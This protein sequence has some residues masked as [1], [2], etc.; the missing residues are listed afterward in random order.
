VPLPAQ[1]LLP[2][3][4]ERDHDELPVEPRVAEPQEKTDA[5]DDRKRAEAEHEPAAARPRQQAVQTVREEDLRDDQ[6]R[7]AID[8]APVVSPDEKH[9]PLLAGLEIVLSPRRELE[10]HRMA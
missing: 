8:L 2:G 9:H 1:E 4:R 6:R 5:E 3:Q 7:R 10:R